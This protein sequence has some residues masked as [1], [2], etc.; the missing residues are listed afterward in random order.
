MERPTL[1]DL[2]N[3]YVYGIGDFDE[4]HEQYNK[5]TL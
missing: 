2:V 5:Q 1:L 4:L 3:A